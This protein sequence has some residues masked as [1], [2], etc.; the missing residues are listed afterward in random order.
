MFKSSDKDNH[1]MAMEIM[2]NSNYV[3]SALY[4]LLLLEEYGHRIADC[5][6][7]NH[8]NFKSMVSYFGLRVRDIKKNS[9]IIV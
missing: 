6:T 8:V 1:I 3:E 7:K 4:L 5:N 9:Y 2:A